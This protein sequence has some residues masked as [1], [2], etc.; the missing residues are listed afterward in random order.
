MTT[1]RAMDIG[2]NSKSTYII[3]RKRQQ[4]ISKNNCISENHTTNSK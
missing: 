2:N 3:H 1:I 4:K